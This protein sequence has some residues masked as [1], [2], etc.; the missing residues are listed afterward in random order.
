M[1]W[2]MALIRIPRPLFVQ[3]SEDALVQ[4]KIGNRDVRD[5]LRLSSAVHVEPALSS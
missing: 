2:P 3:D 5:R 4:I 1:T